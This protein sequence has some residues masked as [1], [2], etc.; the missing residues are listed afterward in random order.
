MSVTIINVPQQHQ[1]AYFGSKQTRYDKALLCPEIAWRVDR[2]EESPEG[3]TN[4]YVTPFD[5]NEA[6]GAGSEQEDRP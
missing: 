3:G 5:Y 2:I 6:S 4:I 1:I